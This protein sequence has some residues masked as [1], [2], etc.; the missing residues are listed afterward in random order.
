[1]PNKLSDEV[2]GE[3]ISP[4]IDVVMNAFGLMFIILVIYIAVFHESSDPLRFLEADPPAAIRG[5][6]Y[7]YS[8]PLVGG[9]GARNVRL[10]RG[11]LG[12]L[13]L[14]L[15]PNLGAVSGL[16][17]TGSVSGRT[18]VNSEEC[19]FEAVDSVG[20]IATTTVRFSV[21]HGAAP[22]PAGEFEIL[23][24][25]GSLHPGRV[26]VRYEAVLGVMG[27]V[28]PSRWSTGKGTRLPAG[29]VLDKQS[30]RIAGTPMEAGTFSLEVL[31]EQIPGGFT[32]NGEKYD[33]AAAEAR[34]SYE[35]VVHAR[36]HHAM[37]LPLG[38][39]GQE[40]GASL[41]TGG[42]LGDEAM[43]WKG[44]V[45]GLRFSSLDGSIRGVPEEAG[46]FPVEYRI[47]NSGTV[48]AEGNGRII[49]LPA[50]PPRTVGPFIVPGVVGLPLDLPIPYRGFQEPVTITAIQ[51]LPDGLS[52][53]KGTIQGT[54]TSPG[55]FAVQINLRDAVGVSAKGAVEMQIQPRSAPLKVPDSLIVTYTVGEPFVWRP[56]WT[57]GRSRGSWSI[58]GAVPAGMSV[59]DGLMSGVAPARGEWRSRVVVVDEMT[60]DAVSR[61]VTFRAVTPDNT[62]VRLI[63]ELAPTAIVGD[64]Y[65]FVLATEGG[66]GPVE[67]LLSGDL[68]PGLSFT[69]NGVR[70]VPSSE[71]EWRIS[72]AVADSTGQR[73][74]PRDY[75]FSVRRTD[76]TPPE[77]RTRTVPAAFL[78]QPY[79]FAFAIS[80]GIG[81]PAVRLNGEL[82]E[83]LAFIDSRIVG[84]A[85]ELGEADIVV[86]ATD[87]AGI[88]TSPQ[89]FLIR[90][91]QPGGAIDSP[92]P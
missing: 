81:I 85:Q 3:S 70:G 4:L 27:D 6:T 58:E 64:E 60:R 22:L 55:V 12:R 28:E 33:W 84:R 56:P 65:S 35:L 51:P 71:G 46:E 44:Q 43:I 87:E 47:G 15:E 90:V 77:M 57:G 29:L 74:G 75:D 80:G 1:M 2:H 30:G 42:R 63:T 9:I 62:P 40:Y 18:P 5:Q 16:A 24:S 61:H 73:D 67:Y 36:L 11:D 10:L 19:E 53:I 37:I 39:V 45:P 14:K 38:R 88:S 89:R 41:V 92:D 23:R 34:G 7:L 59:Q 76:R 78:G 31:A 50:Q 79:D 49:V 68:P 32:Y 20:A 86:T 13:G 25:N 8:L 91:L 54:P 17:S 26:G 69:S 82:P 48:V 72:V 52:L 21:A 66:V 83:G